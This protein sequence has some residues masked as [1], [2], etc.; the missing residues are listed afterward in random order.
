MMSSTTRLL[1]NLTLIAIINKD[2][3]VNKSGGERIIRNLTNFKS[4]KNSTECEKSIKNLVKFKI[5]KVLSFLS[6]T[7][8]LVYTQLR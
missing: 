5:F 4:F 8:I 7:T 1:D 3:A 2:D 6:F